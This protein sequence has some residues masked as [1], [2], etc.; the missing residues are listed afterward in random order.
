MREDEVVALRVRR[1]YT[2]GTPAGAGGGTLGGVGTPWLAGGEARPPTRKRRVCR[3][4]ANAGR[5][6]RGDGGLSGGDAGGLGGAGG[7]GA[8]FGGEGARRV[9]QSGSPC[10]GHSGR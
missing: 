9:P 4:A 1:L 3:R 2:Q 5:A 6:G 8:S 10:P 7:A